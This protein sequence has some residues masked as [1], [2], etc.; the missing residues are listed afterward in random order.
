MRGSLRAIACWSVWLGAVALAAV[1]ATVL[2]LT[3]TGSVEA[4]RWAGALEVLRGTSQAVPADELARLRK[5]EQAERE[6]SDRPGEA[7]LLES[8]RRLRAEEARFERRRKME[9]DAVTNLAAM[10]EG[11]LG[12]IRGE[13][14]EWVAAKAAERDRARAEREDLER[15]ASEKVKRIYRYMDAAAVAAD[16]ESRMVANKD[17]E[18]AELVDAMSDRAAAEVLEAFK[19]PASRMKVYK[20]LAGRREADIPSDGP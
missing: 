15:R 3:L 12:Q 7:T 6:R 19:D 5:I 2:A 16:L 10:A 8:W 17:D 20:A 18:V 11:K 13:K 9:S 4:D 1:A 14:A